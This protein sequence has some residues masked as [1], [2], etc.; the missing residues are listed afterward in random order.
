M[1]VDTTL[2]DEIQKRLI[3]KICRKK[4]A[5]LSFEIDVNQ[6]NRPKF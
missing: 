6:K 1:K 2:I 3:S 5:F 4:S